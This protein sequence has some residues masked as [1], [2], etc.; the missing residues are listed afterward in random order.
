MAFLVIDHIDGGGTKERKDRGA[1]AR[2]F[3]WLRKEGFPPG[4]RVLCHNCNAATSLYGECPHVELE[5][6]ASAA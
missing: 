6:E 1:G 3:A 5:E 4:Y 2:F